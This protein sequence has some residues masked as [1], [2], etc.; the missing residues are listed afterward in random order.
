MMGERQ[1]ASATRACIHIHPIRQLITRTSLAHP[2]LAALEAELPERV[3]GW[4]DFAA[5]RQLGSNSNA[6]LRSRF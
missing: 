4:K 1:A 5:I 3:E 6:L 2:Q